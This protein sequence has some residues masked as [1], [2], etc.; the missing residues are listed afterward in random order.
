MAT[1]HYSIVP[2]RQIRKVHIHIRNIR[3]TL[4]NQLKLKEMRF[5]KPQQAYELVPEHTRVQFLLAFCLV[6]VGQPS[7]LKVLQITHLRNSNIIHPLNILQQLNS[8]QLVRLSVT[9][10]ITTAVDVLGIAAAVH[11][12][13]LQVDGKVVERVVVGLTDDALDVEARGGQV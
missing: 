13:D 7:N 12:Q 2:L 8:R 10:L 9:D 5:L 1:G 11:F 4:L 3:L 6:S